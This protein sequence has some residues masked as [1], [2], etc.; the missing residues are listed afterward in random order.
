MRRGAHSTCCVFEK[1][2]IPQTAFPFWVSPPCLAS[3]VF[4]CP[5]ELKG[6]VVNTLKRG[7]SLVVSKLVGRLSHIFLKEVAQA[8]ACGLV[9]TI[10][11]SRI[12][13]EFTAFLTSRIVRGPW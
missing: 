10:I 4:A 7:F 6:V 11:I 1:R 2:I 8:L 12:F 3:W 5:P 13:F 9:S